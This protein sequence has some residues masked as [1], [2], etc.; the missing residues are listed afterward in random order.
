MPR[1]VPG[2]LSVHCAMKV[3]LYSSSDIIFFQLCTAVL[4]MQEDNKG[5]VPERGLCENSG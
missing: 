1:V 5:G 4:V 2:V 3:L